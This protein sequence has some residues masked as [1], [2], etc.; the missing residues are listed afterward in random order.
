MAVFEQLTSAA[1]NE[2]PAMVDGLVVALLT[3]LEALEVDDGVIGFGNFPKLHSSRRALHR[4]IR[5]SWQA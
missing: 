1:V 5:Y 4:K 3:G 2:L